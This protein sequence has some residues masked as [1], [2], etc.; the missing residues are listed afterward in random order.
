MQEIRDSEK[1]EGKELP[2][3]YESITGKE[4]DADEVQ[5]GSGVWCWSLASKRLENCEES[6]VDGVIGTALKLTRKTV[7]RGNDDQSL[8][9]LV[10]AEER[11][12]CW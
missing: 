1:C 5:E 7:A 9:S 8:R 10:K 2:R 6:G 11:K 12:G 3:V 4:E